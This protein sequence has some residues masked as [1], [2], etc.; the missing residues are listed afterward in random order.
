MN[1]DERDEIITVLLMRN[2]WNKA[3]LE[4]LNNRKLLEEYDRHLRKN[5]G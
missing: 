4:S 2:N 5:R 3:A 1:K